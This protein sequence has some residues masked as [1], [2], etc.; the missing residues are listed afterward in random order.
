MKYLA[1][2]YNPPGLFENMPQPDAD[3][4]FDEYYAFNERARAAG[5]VTGGARLAP[6]GS[7]TTVRVQGGK[8]LVA[9]G[10]FAETKEIL[11]GFFELQCSN[12]DEALDWAAQIPGAR[13]G[14]IEI[15]PV[16][17]T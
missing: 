1:L 2:I 8:R 3:R 5:V 16:V 4:M 13:D 15:R 6:A 9:D 11:G 14:S 17:E 10:P 12:L 7:A